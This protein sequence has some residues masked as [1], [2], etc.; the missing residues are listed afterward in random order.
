MA[1]LA[2]LPLAASLALGIYL[3][4]AGAG[5]SILPTA[6]YELLAGVN[7]DDPG[8]GIEEAEGLSEDSL[9]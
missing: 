4:A 8:T 2:G 3:G 5:A 7:L 1:W 6:A 9:T